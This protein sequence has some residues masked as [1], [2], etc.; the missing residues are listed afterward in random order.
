MTRPVTLR[1]YPGNPILTPSL[2]NA[3]ETDNVFNAAVV[4]HNGLI[5]M[6]YR[7][8]G[9]DRISRI[10]GAISVDGYHFNRLSEPVL[11]PAN[12]WETFGVEDPRVTELDGVFYM[13]YTAYSPHG[14]RVSLA[15]S[16]NLISWERLGVVL[17]DEDNKDA[18]LFPEKIGGRYA[19]F[20]RRPPDIWLA[21]SDDL[22][23]WTDHQIIMRPREG[24]WD[25][26]RVGAGGPPFKT[27]AG[28][29]NVYH[30]YNEARVYCLGIALHALDDP[31]KVL[32]RQEEPILCP[33]APWEVFGDV[34]NVVFTCGGIETED[35]Y[36]IYYGGGD[37]VMA[38]AAIGKGEAM[39]VASVSK[40]EV[41][42]FAQA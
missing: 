28:W 13:L 4:R 32:K 2:T 21:Y 15:R 20:H 10:G 7:A 3:W 9:L 6:L 11:V 40:A 16:T 36:L 39:A 12:E 30:G 8:Q 17:P 29:L 25:S 33:R 27:D 26:V 34:P 41:G 18:V 1:R 31:S 24:M 37:H 22:L 19:M 38:V 14:T 42:E 5:Y 35:E 23:H